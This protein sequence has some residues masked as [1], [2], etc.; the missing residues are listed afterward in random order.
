[1]PDGTEEH[2]IRRPRSEPVRY[3]CS[4]QSAKVISS[5]EEWTASKREEAVRLIATVEGVRSVSIVP[6]SCGRPLDGIYVLVE[7]DV[8]PKILVRT[9]EVLLLNVMNLTIDYRIVAV[10]KDPGQL[11][12]QDPGP[13]RSRG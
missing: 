3:E 6:G 9:I 13:P 1:M 11:L 4:A 2:T 7:D 10:R 12:P 8:I 5:A